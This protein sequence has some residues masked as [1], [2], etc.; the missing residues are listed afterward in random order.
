MNT[1]HS[2]EHDPANPIPLRRQTDSLLMDRMMSLQEQDLR[3]RKRR[4]WLFLVGIVLGPSIYILTVYF[5]LGG[6]GI[7]G[8]YAALV[9]IEGEIGPDSRVSALKINPALGEAFK[10]TKAKGIVLL[11][12]SPGGTPVQ[13]AL[14]HDRIQA[15][16]KAYPGRKVIAVAEDA[17]TSGA[18]FIAV[19]ADKLYVNRSSIVGSI[20]VIMQG[21][22]GGFSVDLEQINKRYGI[23]LDRRV[24]TAG[25]HKDR[26]DAFKAVS[27][28]DETKVKTVLGQ[29]HAHFIDT[30]MQARGTRLHGPKDELF[31]GDFWTGG[32]AVKLGLVDGLSDL[33][34][35]LKQE[36]GVES[37][38]DY[39]PAY[40]LFE[41]LQKSYGMLEDVAGLFRAQLR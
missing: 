1:D 8:D 37:T 34:T 26:L 15:L 2:S 30:V 19:A 7:S 31:S 9:R 25:A 11:I 17:A 24:Y 35:V 4:F 5:V 38:K 28:E 41:R 20:G 33:S 3:F 27:P 14:I 22:L 16:R 21:G 29:M 40:S 10:D 39:S 6:D 36:F 13:S 32:E 23:G 18:Y 12:N